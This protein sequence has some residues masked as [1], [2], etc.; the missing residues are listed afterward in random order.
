LLPIILPLAC[1]H[2]NVANKL[3]ILS[4]AKV[5]DSGISKLAGPLLDAVKLCD[6]PVQFTYEMEISLQGQ[7]RKDELS[8]DG[9]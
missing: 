2:K 3:A 4:I 9:Q 6:P 5:S 7:R 1:A 8:G